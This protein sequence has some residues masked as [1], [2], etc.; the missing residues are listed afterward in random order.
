[1]RVLIGI[2]TYPISDETPHAVYP[3]TLTALQTLDVAGY[4]VA[5]NYYD[6]D[7]PKLDPKDNLTA[8]HNRMRADVLDG[9]YD[10]LL[11]LEADMIVPSDALVKLAAVE[12]DVVYAAYCSRSHPMVL[13]FPQIDGYKGRSIGADAETYRPL[14]G[15]VIESEGVGFGCTL[16]RRKVLEAVE[17]RRDVSSEMKRKFADDWTFAL[18]VKAAGFKSATHLGVLCGHIQRDGR[19]RL[20][21]PQEADFMRIEGEV[22]P[23]H[24]GIALPDVA[25]YRVRRP[26]HAPGKDYKP[27]DTIELGAEAAAILLERRAVETIISGG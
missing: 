3:Q 25:M 4:E 14:F 7:D 27:G 20:V 6:G 26:V 24:K 12:A 10:A 22:K 19:V 21:D 9:G 1:M 18:D 17:F 16:I 11:T 15:T 23:L 5:I 2:A 13:T 8:K